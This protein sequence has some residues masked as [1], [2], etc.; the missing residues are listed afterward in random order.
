MIIDDYRDYSYEQGWIGNKFNYWSG[1][2]DSWWVIKCKKIKIIIILRLL[3]I[4]CTVEK[5]NM[6]HIHSSVT[7]SDIKFIYEIY[8]NYKFN[9]LEIINSQILLKKP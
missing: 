2:K 4:R 6:F 3:I 5:K 9:K 8:F 7:D 1:N